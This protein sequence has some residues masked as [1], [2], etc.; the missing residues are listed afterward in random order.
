MHLLNIFLIAQL[1][2][3][4]N[5]LFTNTLLRCFLNIVILLYDFNL[6][7]HN[8]DF[9]Y[10]RLLAGFLKDPNNMELLILYNNPNLETIL[11]PDLFPDRHGYWKEISKKLN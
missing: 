11:F 8:K 6:E 9:Y 5:I 1:I 4:E 7:I 10:S 3:N 2:D